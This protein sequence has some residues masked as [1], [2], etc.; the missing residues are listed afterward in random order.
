MRS[1]LHDLEAFYAS[2]Q[3]QV[4]RRLLAHQIRRI[5]PDV[6]GL[7]VLGIGYAGPYLGAFD[8]AA[9]CI[10]A[11]SAHVNRFPDSERAAPPSCVSTSFLSRT[12]RSIGSC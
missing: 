12:A 11:T 5:W 7:D 10:S 8:G 1:D 4:A 6:D 2:R 3:G 9:R